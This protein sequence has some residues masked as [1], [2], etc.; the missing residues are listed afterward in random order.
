MVKFITR[1]KEKLEDWAAWA[2]DNPHSRFYRFVSHPVI[3]SFSRILPRA[4][5]WGSYVGFMASSVMSDS[6]L[7]VWQ[8]V[9]WGVL[10]F[11]FVIWFVFGVLVLLIDNWC[12]K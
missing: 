10:L 6:E 11:H 1:Y 5:L 7:M 4:F 12:R 8:D 2:E 9:S 3:F